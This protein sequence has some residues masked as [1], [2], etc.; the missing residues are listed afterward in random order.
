[1]ALEK[2]HLQITPKELFLSKK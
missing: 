1:M 2:L